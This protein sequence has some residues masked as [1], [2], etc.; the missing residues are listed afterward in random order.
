MIPCSVYFPTPARKTKCTTPFYLSQRAPG[1]LYIAYRL[2]LLP[3]FRSSAFP[4]I[5]VVPQYTPDVSSR[6]L[7]HDPIFSHWH[8]THGD[9]LKMALAVLLL[10]WDAD[11]HLEPP[12]SPLRIENFG[13]AIVFGPPHLVKYF[14][15]PWKVSVWVGLRFVPSLLCLCLFSVLQSLI[16]PPF[17]AA[18]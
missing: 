12:F 3:H 8:L 1:I 5:Q 15:R 18:T 11:I 17:C 10:V 4:S 6:R 2:K 7:S 14:L 9:D 16:Y 13:S